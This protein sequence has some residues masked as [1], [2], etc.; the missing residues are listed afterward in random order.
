MRVLRSTRVLHQLPSFHHR[1]G[2][3]LRRRTASLDAL[4]AGPVVLDLSEH[5]G[6]GAPGS[7]V[8]VPVGD[9]TA[10]HKELHAT[11]YAR[12]NPGIEADSPWKSST[13]VQHHSLLANHPI[14]SQSAGRS[15]TGL[16]R[17]PTIAPNDSQ[18]T[19]ESTAFMRSRMSRVRCCRR[20]GQHSQ[21][22]RGPRQVSDFC[23]RN[24]QAGSILAMAFVVPAL[25]PRGEV[26]DSDADHDQHSAFSE[27]EKFVHSRS[28]SRAVAACSK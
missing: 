1:V 13:V 15:R 6:N 18:R 5:H 20:S 28:I 12:M 2:A 7:T 10:L 22:A 25:Q 26:V 3:P 27:D 9:V 24:E 11:G 16:A 23:P 4:A 14:K 17:R 8:W 21:F 19:R